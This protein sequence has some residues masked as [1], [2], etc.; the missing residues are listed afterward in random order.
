[1]ESDQQKPPLSAGE[2]IQG[3]LK[4]VLGHIVVERPL[5]VTHRVLVQP[6]ASLRER[7]VKKFLG[8]PT[9][10]PPLDHRE[11]SFELVLLARDQRSIILR[12]EHFA[13]RRDVPEESARWLHVLHQAPQFGERVLHWCRGEK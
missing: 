9:E 10:R 1:M 5:S 8:L 12:A 7:P 11:T 13:E 3:R 6:A 2:R 4:E